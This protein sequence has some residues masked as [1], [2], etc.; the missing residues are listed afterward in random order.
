MNRPAP[1]GSSLPDWYRG[2]AIRPLADM[3]IWQAG[4]DWVHWEQYH[5]HFQ[6]TEGQ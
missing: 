5:H 4:L 2:R 6:E 1:F 3:L